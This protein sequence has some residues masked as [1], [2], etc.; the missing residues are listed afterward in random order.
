MVRLALLLAVLTLVALADA[1]A[2]LEPV[3]DRVVVLS[4]EFRARNGL[5]PLQ[6]NPSLARAAR[7]HSD[8]MAHLNYFDHESPTLGRRYP[9]DRVNLL[10]SDADAISEN[11]YLAEGYPLD[12][13]A[14][15]ALHSW[16]NSPDHR[17]NL[18]DPKVTNVGVG[19]A[20]HGGQIYVTQVFSSAVYAKTTSRQEPGV[21]PV[22]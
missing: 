17:H 19:I 10:G 22:N 11:L 18:L 15:M 13:V 21:A 12:Q 7:S 5:P 2:P 20:L 9:W 8:E 14:A 4:N 6:S 16:E 1:P 3:E